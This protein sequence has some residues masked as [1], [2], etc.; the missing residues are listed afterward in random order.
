MLIPISRYT[1][2][3]FQ[4]YLGF[5]KIP[6]Y[7]AHLRDFQ[8]FIK[9][10]IGI[11]SAPPFTT[12]SKYTISKHLRVV[13]VFEQKWFSLIIW[14]IL[15]SPKI[16]IIGF[17]NRGHVQKSR[18]HENNRF[19]VSPMMKSKSDLSKMKQNNTKELSV[20]SSN[21]IYNINVSPDPLDPKSPNFL[22]CPGSSAKKVG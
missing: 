18:N 8:Q 16:N 22:R 21:N 1:K 20:I 17:G 2:F 19:S 13:F 15:V 9:R 4:V 14:N 10:I 7:G 6:R 12:C 3:P 5:T 11:C